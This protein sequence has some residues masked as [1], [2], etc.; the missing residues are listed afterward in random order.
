MLESAGSAQEFYNE[1][2][3]EE[4]IKARRRAI[5]KEKGKG[6]V[7]VSA[8]SLLERVQAVLVS[9]FLLLFG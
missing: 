8:I 3:S 2:C 5:R 7:C 9:F 1:L 4:F 6:S